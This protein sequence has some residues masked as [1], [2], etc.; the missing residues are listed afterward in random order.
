[1]NRSTGSLVKL[2]AGSIAAYAAWRAAVYWSRKYDFA[3]RVVVIT[4]GSRGLGL[5]L[6]RQ[7]ADEGAHIAI[8]A[9]HERELLR[10][11]EDL[12][13][14]GAR[15]V[16]CACDITQRHEVNDFFTLVRQQLGPVD[17]LINNAGIIQVG[18]L[19]TI[20]NED[21]AA[22]MDIHFWAPLW[23]TEAALPD[24]RRR[25]DGRIVNVSSIGGQ[26][27]VPHLLPYCASKFALVGFSDCLRAEMAQEGVY[28]TTACPGVMRT[29]SPRNA[30]FKGHH[31]AEFAWFSILSSQ[32]GITVSAE[33]AARQI[34]RACRYGRAKIT[35]S[36]PAKLA[37]RA[38]ALA[39]ELTADL[40]S[41][42]NRLLPGP[43]GI[44]TSALAGSDSQSSW[45]PSVLTALSDQ[46]AKRNNETNG[47][48]A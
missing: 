39:Q 17:V 28:V 1:M 45:S 20:T 22:A 32:P 8:C 24:M 7:L 21:Y 42:T 18:P 30:M 27:A 3:N 11:K 35:L 26:I 29:G 38:A 41:L 36:L 23:A 40:S 16:A 47:A 34:I 25:R 48:S 14:R 6:A 12:Q 19:D 31:R 43:G 2:A 5:V 44:G 13:Q 10:A 37:V 33:R 4:G 9:R 15:V 46:A